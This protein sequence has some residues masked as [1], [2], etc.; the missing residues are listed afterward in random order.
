[1]VTVRP[2][3]ISP[4]TK[5]LVRILD[6]FP[7]FFELII[8]TQKSEYVCLRSEEAEPVNLQRGLSNEFRQVYLVIS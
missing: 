5:S 4:V 3:I 8:T 2:S 7:H 6:V 1:M